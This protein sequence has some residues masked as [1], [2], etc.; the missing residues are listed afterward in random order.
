MMKQGSG[1]IINNTAHRALRKFVRLV[2]PQV[3]EKIREAFEQEK[4]HIKYLRE[5]GYDINCKIKVYQISKNGMLPVLIR[6]DTSDIDVFYEIHLKNS[7]AP[8]VEMILSRYGKKPLHI[9][10]AGANTGLSIIYFEQFFPGSEYIAIEPAADTVRMLRRNM[11]HNS[12]NSRVNILRSA[13][14]DR[15]RETL[16]L[17]S[18]FRDE[19]SWAASVMTP[20]EKAVKVK[21]VDLQRVLDHLGSN[22]IAD[23]LKIDIEGAEKVLFEDERFLS[24]IHQRVRFLCAEIHEE[25]VDKPSL[26]NA[27]SACG[28]EWT[29]INNLVYAVNRNLVT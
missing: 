22:H 16:S 2:N 24:N 26:L 25:F 9:I 3:A 8:M 28:F 7:Y 6:P 13:L 23:L 5:E 15:N 11:R 27:L 17:S 20:S 10:D 4:W 12:M 14:W 18:S 19:R 1:Q 21:T 29:E